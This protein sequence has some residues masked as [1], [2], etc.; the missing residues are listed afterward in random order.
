MRLRTISSRDELNA[1]PVT[2]DELRKTVVVV[3]GRAAGQGSTLNVLRRVLPWFGFWYDHPSWR[4]GV[5]RCE[6]DA[7]LERPDYT[8]YRPQHLAFH[9][10]MTRYVRPPEYTA[11]R[12]L[13][14]DKSGGENLMLHIDD[15][16]SR[17][18]QRGRF[19]ILGMLL[20][21]R[22]MSVD[23]R[24]LLPSMSLSDS[25]ERPI[26]VEGDE[27]TPS[28]VFDRHAASKG[29]H[30][31]MTENEA[32]LYDEFL[33]LCSELQDI[34]V[35][36]LLQPNDLLLFSNWRF[37]HSRTQCQG[38]G[39]VTEIC[40]GSGPDR[41]DKLSEPTPPIAAAKPY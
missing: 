41:L 26:L 7:E 15:V 32:R 4:T 24:H 8:A 29:S 1:S 22:T 39:R 19:D 2:A 6:V 38:S 9:N 16:I 23:S 3:A 11:I 34:E 5:W 30:L 37:L 17:L 36:V 18:R 14:A 10:D 20:R 13:I 25:I 31:S 27:G 28:R 35:R 21:P 33:A 12:C 40:M